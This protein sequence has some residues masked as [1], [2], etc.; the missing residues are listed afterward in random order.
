MATDLLVSGL[1]Q[2]GIARAGRGRPSHPEAAGEAGAASAKPAREEP[3]RE[4]TPPAPPPPP[5]AEKRE[6]STAP[7]TVKR[8]E[9]CKDEVSFYSESGE[10]E[11]AV[12]DREVGPEA[13][14]LKA[15]PKARAEE[16]SEIPR[17]RHSERRESRHRRSAGRGRAGHRDR[18]HSHRHR[19]RGHEEE[20]RHR[21]RTPTT[22]WANGRTRSGIDLDTEVVHGIRKSGG[23][24]RTPSGDFIIDAQK[25]TGIGTLGSVDWRNGAPKEEGRRRP[26]GAKPGSKRGEEFTVSPGM[27]IPWPPWLAQ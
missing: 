9:P 20:H 7:E 19:E 23:L 11:E 16:R 25:N 22:W 14:G 15:V 17:R 13:S 3:P 1:A 4:D 12:D 5:E 2:V 26:S 18:G 8:E 6:Q 21:S 24:S 10:S 27:D